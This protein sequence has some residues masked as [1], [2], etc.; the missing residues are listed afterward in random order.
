MLKT[1]LK[2]SV[3]LSTFLQVGCGKGVINKAPASDNSDS[4]IRFITADSFKLSAS[5]DQNGT[6]TDSAKSFDK[7]LEL[8]IPASLDVTEGN[9]GNGT[10][11]IYFNSNGE[12]GYDFYCKYVG[13]ASSATPTDE[14]EIEKGLKYNFH[15]CYTQENDQGQISFRPGEAITQYDNSSVVF[16][17]KSADPTEKTKVQADI[18]IDWH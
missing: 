3:I 9:A 17:V 1:I 18:E 10:A 5:I 13:G 16:S 6:A 12:T 11:A 4:A 15:D 8:R 7:D 14:T 2:S